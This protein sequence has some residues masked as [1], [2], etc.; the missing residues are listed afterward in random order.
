MHNSQKR[1]MSCYVLVKGQKATT[2]KNCS[3]WSFLLFSSTLYKWLFVNVW[4]NFQSRHSGLRCSSPAVSCTYSLTSL[5][6]HTFSPKCCIDILNWQP[7]DVLFLGPSLFYNSSVCCFSFNFLPIWQFRKFWKHLLSM[8]QE[9]HASTWLLEVG[10]QQ[11][12]AISSLSGSF[13]WLCASSTVS[14]EFSPR[15]TKCFYFTQISNSSSILIL[16][17]IPAQT[18]KSNSTFISNVKINSHN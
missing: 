10:R 1:K 11:L 15:R 5:P 12:R 6:R 7:N 17:S 4:P 2:I 18:M 3:C 14:P 9:I 16:L 13:M 8:I